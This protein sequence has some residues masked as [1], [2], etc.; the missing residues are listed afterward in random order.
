MTRSYRLVE[1]RQALK[2]HLTPGQDGA[3]ASTTP[4]DFFKK[5]LGEGKEQTETW[6]G[7]MI[8]K[9]DIRSKELNRKVIGFLFPVK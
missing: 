5:I 3:T 4:F 1:H 6:F 9:S 8:Q 7:V 2:L